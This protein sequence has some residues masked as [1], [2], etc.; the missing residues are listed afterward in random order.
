MPVVRQLLE[1]RE[2]NATPNASPATS[3]ATPS[4]QTHKNSEH[5]ERINL[6]LPSS[7]PKSLWETGCAPGLVTKEHRLR[8]AQADDALNELRRQLRISASILDYKKATIKGTSQ[9][10]GTRARTVMVR[11]HDKTYRCAERY[12]AAYRALTIF[13]PDGIWNR[14]LLPLDHAKDLRLPR[15]DKDDDPTSEGRRALSWIWLVSPR[16]GRPTEVATQDEVNDSKL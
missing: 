8:L 12:D 15:R 1:D 13:D 4:S 5:P 3:Q 16:E 9:K 7:L 11:F 6:W 2:S 14:R 10:M